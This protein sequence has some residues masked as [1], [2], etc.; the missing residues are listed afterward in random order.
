MSG[1]GEAGVLAA[2]SDIQRSLD[3]CHLGLYGR[4]LSNRVW[5]GEIKRALADLGVVRGYDICGSGFA[6]RRRCYGEWLYDLCWVEYADGDDRD[7]IR[8]IPL[9]L[10]SEWGVR[11]DHADVLEDFQKLC[12][13]RAELLWMVFQCDDSAAFERIC[14]RLQRQRMIFVGR[15]EA[16]PCMVSGWLSRRQAPGFVHRRIG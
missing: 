4:G 11:N 5:T 10:E 2:I 7:L 3:A 14:A 12:Q 1:A 13:A 16:A 15:G 9:A 8:R 6:G